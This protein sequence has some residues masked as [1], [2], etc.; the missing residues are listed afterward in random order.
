MAVIDVRPLRVI[1]NAAILDGIRN[2]AS[3]DYQRRIPAA[4]DAGITDTV[5]NLTK[6]RPH[7]NEFIDALVN[8]IG[9][10]I[11]RNT[12]W[13]NPMAP[14]KRG[15]L[16]FG[17]TIEEIQVGL[18]EAHR[19]DTDR[20]YMERDLFGTEPIDVQSNFH[21]LNRQDYYKITIDENL[22]R[23]AFLEPNGLS[24]FINQM[25]QAPSTSDQWDEFLLMTSLFGKYEKN[26]G[27]HHVHTPDLID[28][29]S[30]GD[31][32]KKV[33]R[34]MRAM[35]DNLT[36][37]STKYNAAHM[38]TFADRDDLCIFVTPEFNAAVDVEALA[39]AFNV[40][41][42]DMTG[43]IYPIP[44]DLFGIEGCQ[45]IMTTKDF[46]VVAD[47]ALDTTSQF[48][49]VTRRTNYFLHHW[50]IISASRFVPAVM[51]TTGAD[52]EVIVVHDKPKTVG[53]PTLTDWQEETVTEVQRGYVYQ[54]NVPTET[55]QGETVPLIY[56][57]IGK[58]SMKTWVSDTGVL[59]VGGDEDASS[60]I[61]T[62]RSAM[63]DYDDP[64]KADMMSTALTLSVTG[65][66]VPEWPEVADGV[67]A[68]DVAG[69]T[70]PYV[71]GQTT[72]TATIPKG[73]TLS[74]DDVYVSTAGSAD[75][76]V[77]ITGNATAG[78]TVTISVDLG[79]GT[80]TD[81]TVTVTP[82]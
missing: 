49:A 63:V 19:Y 16:T 4:D 82:V 3:L 34:K 37:L 27:F 24:T 25:M 21:R 41:K 7:M 58:T 1:D 13:T 50:Q 2:D 26:G 20:E 10:T 71:A 36:F 79:T 72:Y 80:A 67:L 68:I 57:V 56:S 65:V 54:V 76:S 59:H 73:T 53:T 60:L 81:Y 61:V 48:N 44:N 29:E 32:A 70:I 39:G 66:K 30:N 9:M 43:K 75:S 74:R 28:I 51:F 78:Y 18:L 15:L 52:D 55:E 6:Y 8:R 77:K 46:F 23:R 12:S 62:A 47:N 69:Q 40:S 45:A 31:D 33:L 38:P 35:A 5:N 11:A 42:T 22:L 64:R 17:D 14:F